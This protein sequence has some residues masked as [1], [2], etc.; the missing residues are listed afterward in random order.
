MKVHRTKL[1]SLIKNSRGKIFSCV[2]IKKDGSIRR[3][4]CRLGVT[5]YI[6]G[7]GKAISNITN[8][9][10]TVFDLSKDSYRVINIDTINNIT[11][12]GLTYN[13]KD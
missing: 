13:V 7:T 5:K 4:T 11:I 12:G 6:K 10:V 1:E 8:S 9:Y 3:M 2:F